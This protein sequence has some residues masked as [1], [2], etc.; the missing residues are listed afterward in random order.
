MVIMSNVVILNAFV[1]TRGIVRLMRCGAHLGSKIPGL[2]LMPCA[3]V[4]HLLRSE[5]VT[6]AFAADKIL[7][8]FDEFLNSPRLRKDPKLCNLI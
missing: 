2:R 6:I 8:A 4:R 1:D 5:R 3:G 7:S